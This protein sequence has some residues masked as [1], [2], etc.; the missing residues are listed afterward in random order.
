VRWRQATQSLDEDT[1]RVL[2]AEL[3]YNIEVVSP[4]DEERELL[5]QFNIDLEAELAGESDA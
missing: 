3:G 1:F 5:G 2:G 4:E